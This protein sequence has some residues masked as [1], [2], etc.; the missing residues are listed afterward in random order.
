LQEVLS[1]RPK[2]LLLDEPFSALDARTREKLRDTLKKAISEYSTT[3][4]HVTHDFE[5]VWAL[6]NRVVVIRKGRSYAGRRSRIRLSNGLLPDFVA[7][8]LAQMC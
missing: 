6:A 1:V 3:V 4:L 2:L 5:D 7:E 8:F